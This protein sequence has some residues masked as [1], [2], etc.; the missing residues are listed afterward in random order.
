MSPAKF[1][2]EYEAALLTPP[3]CA[4]LCGEKIQVRLY[5]KHKGIP[6][7]IH[8]H[9]I[10]T[11]EAKN[12]L[13]ELN[14]GKVQSLKT[15]KKRAK[16][17]LGNTN[18]L[19]YIHT[20][21][22][23]KNHSIRMIGNTYRLGTTQP[24]AT[25]LLFSRQRKNKKKK[26]KYPDI[27]LNKIV[28]CQCKDEFGGKC[29]S[30]IEIKEFHKRRGVPRFSPGHQLSNFIKN[31]TSIELKLQELLISKNISFASQ[32][33]ISLDNTF[34]KVDIFIE[35]NICIFADGDYW[36]ANLI[37]FKLSDKIRGGLTME[38]KRDK[39]KSINN[40]L[41]KRGY[42]VLRFWESDIRHDFQLVIDKLEEVVSLIVK[43]EL[44]SEVY[45]NNLGGN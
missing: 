32:K 1:Q 6:K 24:E 14:T 36:H 20:E 30:L 42:R 29:D 21:E 44:C 28:Y 22:Q 33:C 7:Y 3:L 23:V 18:G 10:T 19:G 25:R 13:I 11:S 31:N 12:N 35:P 34:T 41:L 2:V 39:D 17:L 4:C 45:P 38:Q 5:H 15:R 43:P 16:S 26:S 37:K 9:Y 8:G 27:D 40:L